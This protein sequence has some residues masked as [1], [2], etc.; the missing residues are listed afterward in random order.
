MAT[1]VPCDWGHVSQPSTQSACVLHSE[2]PGLWGDYMSPI[3]FS[4]GCYQALE[5]STAWMCSQATANARSTRLVQIFTRSQPDISAR[6][7]GN[8]LETSLLYN[9]VTFNKQPK[10]DPRPQRRHC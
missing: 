10:T 5:L 7:G 4:L 2:M 6:R 1:A 8:L 3:T 9:R